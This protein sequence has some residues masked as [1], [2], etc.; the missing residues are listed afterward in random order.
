MSTSAPQEAV[1]AVS[2][3]TVPTKNEKLIAWVEEVAELTKPDAVHWCDGSA[4]EYDRLCQLLVDAGTFTQ[5]ER[6]QAAELLP[7][8]GRTRATSRASRTARSSAPST[9]TTPAPTNNWEAP[10]EMREP[11]TGAVRRRRCG[12]HD[13][14]R[15]VL[16]GPARLGQVPRRRPADRLAVR[17]RLDADHDPHGPGRARRARRR[18][19]V[20]A[21]RALGRHAARGRRRG[22]AVAVQRR[23]VHRPL[24]RDARDLVLRLGLRRQRAARQEVLRA[25]HRLGDGPRRGLDGRAHADPQADLARGR[26][27]STSPARSRP[28][29][30]RRTS[31]C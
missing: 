16:D 2:E 21:L 19:R 5:A 30:A 1:T 7:R 11:L 12:P 23:E 4:E 27:S 3:V 31:R 6:R 26:R 10:A 14:R 9:S 24:P 13:V 29:A 8:A 18:R 25:A 22:R 17:R 20:R 28:P 15:A